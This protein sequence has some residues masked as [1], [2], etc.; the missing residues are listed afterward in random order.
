MGK[1]VASGI[2][3]AGGFGYSSVVILSVIR[4]SPP[5]LKR[6]LVIEIFRGIKR[7]VSRLLRLALAARFAIE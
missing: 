3:V 2:N 4:P 5:S 1:Y 7:D 6:D